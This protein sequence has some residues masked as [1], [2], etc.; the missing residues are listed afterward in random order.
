MLNII[1]RKKERKK[2]VIF[3]TWTIMA[4]RRSQMLSRPFIVNICLDEQM[5]KRSPAG[6]DENLQAHKKQININSFNR[7]FFFKILVVNSK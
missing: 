2:S 1:L 5:Q 3:V 4:A 6:R 7:V